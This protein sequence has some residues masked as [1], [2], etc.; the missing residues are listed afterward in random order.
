MV[1]CTDLVWTS[2]D[3]F[4]ELPNVADMSVNAYL[5]VYNNKTKIVTDDWMMHLTI[6]NLKSIPILQQFWVK[7]P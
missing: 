5:L 2:C 4:A 7:L 1:W 6:T 3:F